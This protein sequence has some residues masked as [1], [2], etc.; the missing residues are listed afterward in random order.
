MDKNF[1]DLYEFVNSAVKSRKYP[2]STAQ[3]LRAALKLYE[4]ELNEEEQGSIDSF[5]KNIDQ[6]AQAV[7]GKN[8]L[9]F[10]ATSLATYKSRV[11]KVVNDYEKYGTDP[12]KMASWSPKLVARAK[13][14]SK[15]QEKASPDNGAQS[16]PLMPA[17]SVASTTLI[18]DFGSG[19]VAQIVLPSDATDDERQKLSMLIQNM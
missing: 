1:K 14:G 7:F 3:T 15:Q 6:I 19:R 11:L 5:R 18:K 2:E 17:S 9:K 4:Q 12:T 10:S 16:E 13:R 8:K